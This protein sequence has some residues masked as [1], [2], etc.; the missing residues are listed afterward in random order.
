MANESCYSFGA[1]EEYLTVAELA[2][3]IK[4]SR[5][6]LYNMISSGRFVRGTHY[7]K[8]CRKKV[9]FLWS[10]IRVWVEYDSVNHIDEVKMAAASRINI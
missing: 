1:A 6:T 2:K 8:P 4:L 9:L 10:A 3:R 5:Q 7:V